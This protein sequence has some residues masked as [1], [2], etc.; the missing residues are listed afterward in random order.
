[1]MYKTGLHIEKWRKK[2]V[3]WKSDVIL[4]IECVSHRFRNTISHR[5]DLESFYKHILPGSGNSEV[6]TLHSEMGAT[7]DYI[8]YTPKRILPFNQKGMPQNRTVY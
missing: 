3:K 7:V 6:T 5:L 4:V 2:Q 8:F 1:M